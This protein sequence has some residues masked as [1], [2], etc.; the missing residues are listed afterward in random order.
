MRKIAVLFWGF[1]AKINGLE[2]FKL[3]SEK[4][5]I[6]FKNTGFRRKLRAD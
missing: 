5:V 3:C 2:K 4:A 1:W 6:L